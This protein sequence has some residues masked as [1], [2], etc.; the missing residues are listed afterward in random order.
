YYRILNKFL[1]AAERYRVNVD[2]K[3]IDGIDF[4]SADS[5]K[6]ISRNLR[7]FDDNVVDGFAEG[8]STQSVAIS[9][10]SQSAQTGR[11]N[12][13]VGVILFGIGILL[14]VVLISM[15]VL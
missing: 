7:W 13:Y 1:D 15:G 3:I 5:G 9:E 14:I 4:K 8:V 11:V 2:N 6:A 10:S 12:D